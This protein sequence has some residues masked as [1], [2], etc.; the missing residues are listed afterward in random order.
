MRPASGGL[1]AA[2]PDALPGGPERFLGAISGIVGTVDDVASAIGGGGGGGSG[3]CPGAADPFKRGDYG[4]ADGAPAVQQKASQLQSRF[5][6]LKPVAQSNP[7]AKQ[8]LKRV[9]GLFSTVAPDCTPPAD[10]LERLGW[11]IG[12]AELQVSASWPA[13][14]ESIVT[15]V[16]QAATGSSLQTDSPTPGTTG[17]GI[18]GPTVGGVPVVGWVA[19]VVLVAGLAWIGTRR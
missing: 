19:L 18:A 13:T 8:A 7:E 2:G 6:Q 17:P 1:T 14:A 5:Q 3:A 11:A 15:E 10:D 16:E 4:A 12:V 9:D